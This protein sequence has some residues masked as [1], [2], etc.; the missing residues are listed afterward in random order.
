MDRTQIIVEVLGE[1]WPRQSTIVGD[2][3]L[4]EIAS[5]AL[6]GRPSGYL[7]GSGGYNID[8]S[9]MLEA[10]ANGAQLVASII[11]AAV[12]LKTRNGATQAPYDR[13][14]RT[15]AVLRRL[16]HRH[17]FNDDELR[18]V[19]RSVL[20]RLRDDSDWDYRSQW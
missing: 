17:G 2:R 7:A 5:A 16:S 8:P 14:D 3:A 20:G 19:C 18:A 4:R 9:S 15:D 12:L 13:E 1:H 10:V 11:A 6:E